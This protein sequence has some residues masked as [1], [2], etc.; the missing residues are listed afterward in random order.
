VVAA[1]F[2]MDRTL[3][4]KETATLY[5]RY[6]RKRGGATWRDSARVLWW[7]AQYTLGVLDMPAVAAR[8]LRGLEGTC[9][10]ELERRCD[11]WFFRDIR[12]L[13]SEVGR[14]AVNEHRARGDVVA[15]VT[16]AMPYTARPLARLLGIEH[17]VASDLEVAPDGRMTGRFVDPLCVGQGKLERA[18]ALATRLGFPLERATFYSDSYT[19]LPLLEAVG[20]P[21]TVNPD[22]RLTRIARQRGWRVERW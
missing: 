18:R 17:I 19:D 7:V 2:D 16:G 22:P 21:V 1:L 5:V 15:I 11:D 10:T 3:V 12:P 8:A 13:V 6:M 14:R 20:T 4:R 9:E